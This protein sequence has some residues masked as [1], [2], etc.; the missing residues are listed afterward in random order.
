MSSRVFLIGSR[1]TSEKI[2]PLLSTSIEKHITGYGANSLYVGY[3]GDFDRM[4]LG[5]LRQLKEKY[6]SIM[7]YLVEPY[8]FSQPKIEAP[9][10]FALY[11]PNIENVP[12]PLAIVE[13]NK[14][15]VKT[16]DYLIICPS[17]VGN[18]RKIMEMAKKIEK[19]GLIKVTVIEN[20]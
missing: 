6:P 20:F 16:C 9:Q 4:C 7:L 14:Q 8:A 18:S 5:V 13:A 3:R 1:Y 12:L 19:K 17:A 10:G 11:Y 15:M 2:R